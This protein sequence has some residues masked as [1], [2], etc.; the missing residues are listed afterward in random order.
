MKTV[1]LKDNIVVEII[2]E[3]ALPVEKWYGSAFAEQC[4]EAPDEV[5]QNWAYN[6]ETGAFSVSVEPEPLTPAQQRETAYNTQP[7]IEWEDKQ[8]TVTQA[9]TKWQYY[10]A[11]GSTKADEVQALIAAAKQAI[12]EQ[13]PDEVETDEDT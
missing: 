12:R 1:R 11:E 5:E 3:Y 9:A 13:Y 6:P 7:I 4:L 2:P 10:A 8:L